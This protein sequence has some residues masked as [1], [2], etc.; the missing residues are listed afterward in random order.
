MK[1]AIAATF[2]ALVATFSAP[3]MAASEHNS[4]GA[5]PAD[6]KMQSQAP[7]DAPMVDGTVKKVDKAAG[8]VTLSHGPLTNLGMSMPMT[9]AFRVKDAMWLE[10]MKEGDKIRFVADSINGA[11][12]V[13]KFEPV[14]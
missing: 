3:G 10:Q 2:I 13:V 8:K 14:K 9:M 1:T 12:T 4:H 5:M 11:I 7:A 6:M